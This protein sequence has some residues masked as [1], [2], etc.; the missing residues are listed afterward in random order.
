ML[1]QRAHHI[2]QSWSGVDGGAEARSEHPPS[3]CQASQPIGYVLRLWRQT[4]VC[5]LPWRDLEP[6]SSL[7]RASVFP[8]LKWND[9]RSILELPED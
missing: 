4:W 8:S 5:I 9:K 3:S 2:H 1:V 6:I 7:S